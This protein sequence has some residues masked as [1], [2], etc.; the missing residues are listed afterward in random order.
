M[1]AK[2]LL[3]IVTFIVA[4]EIIGITGSVFTIS[5]IPT[6]YASLNKPSFNPPNWIFGPVW[7]ILYATLGLSAYLIW[8]KGWVNKDVKITLGIFAL[9]FIV[10]LKW[11]FL[12]FGLHS[13]LLGLIAIAIL[14]VLI[15]LTIIKFYQLSKPAGLLMIPYLLWVSFATLL[16]FYIWKL[17]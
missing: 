8:K 11:T 14:W 10:N 6:W 15:V 4:A 9:Q 7:T 2:T 1:K 3:Q 13:T 17:N 16:N 5:S 12:F